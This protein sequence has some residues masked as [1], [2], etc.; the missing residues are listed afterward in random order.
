MFFL[1]EDAGKQCNSP[2]GTLADGHRHSGCP[3]RPTGLEWT[4]GSAGKPYVPP[5][6]DLGPSLIVCRTPS[7][8]RHAAGWTVCPTGC[9]AFLEH[10][11]TLEYLKREK[12]RSEPLRLE[13]ISLKLTLT[14]KHLR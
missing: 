11:P 14:P 13:Y 5:C 4:A 8:C 3:R 7:R 6:H 1:D 2:A 10:P 12:L 9:G